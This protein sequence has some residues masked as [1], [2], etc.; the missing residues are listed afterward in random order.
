MSDPGKFR[1]E[2]R[3]VIQTRHALKLVHGR[4]T[5]GE[6]PPIPGLTRF[7][8]QMSHIFHCSRLD[9]PYADLVM[10]QVEEAIETAHQKLD[11]FE[12]ALEA[13]FDQLEGLE[14]D[15]GHSDN[16]E[17]IELSFANPYSY[18]GA[19]LVHRYDRIALRAMTARHVGLMTRIETDRLLHSAGQPLR[20]L[21]V[22]PMWYAFTGVTRKDVQLGTAAA[23]KA[24]ERF[25]KLPQDVLE[26]TRRPEYAPA[27]LHQVPEGEGIED[28]DAWRA[29]EGKL[30]QQA[31]E[32]T[33]RRKVGS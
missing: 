17:R 32:K 1:K 28:L 12:E 2:A 23:A 26:G 29:E 18:L 10:L 13:R 11:R 4:R 19:V 30:L 16:P 8:A 24:E 20:S 31:Q 27:I 33:E 5:D 3:L 6:K 7:G 15:I 14:V 21:F 22:R 25:G 9:D